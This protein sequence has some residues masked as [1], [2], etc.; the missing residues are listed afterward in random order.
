M[1]GDEACNQFA[2]LTRPTST[3]NGGETMFVNVET[4]TI[5][6]QR[7]DKNRTL[8]IEVLPDE[9]KVLKLE[10]GEESLSQVGIGYNDYTPILAFER[11]NDSQFYAC[12]DSNNGTAKV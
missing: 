6:S 4:K 9:R 5:Q 8:V 7:D 10:C 2:A 11:D 3:E 12:D 1:I